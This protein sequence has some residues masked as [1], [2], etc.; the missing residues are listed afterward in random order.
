MSTRRPWRLRQLSKSGPHAN[1][2]TSPTSVRMIDTPSRIAMPSRL[3]PHWV[4]QLQGCSRFRAHHRARRHSSLSSSSGYC[5]SRSRASASSTYPRLIPRAGRL[6]LEL[7]AATLDCLAGRN[8]KHG[9]WFLRPTP[10]R[11]DELELVAALAVEFPPTTGCIGQVRIARTVR[12]ADDNLKDV[13]RVG[14]GT[15]HGRCVPQV[16]PRAP[17]TASDL[18]GAASRRGQPERSASPFDWQKGAIELVHRILALGCPR[19]AP[20]SAMTNAPCQP[21]W[22]ATA[23]NASTTASADAPP[24]D[25]PGQQRADPR[26]PGPTVSRAPTCGQTRLNTSGLSRLLSGGSPRPSVQQLRHPQERFS[27]GTREANQDPFH[28]FQLTLFA[29]G[30]M[31]GSHSGAE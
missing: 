28:E 26:H 11:H 30:Q 17:R 18:A 2:S 12:L 9:Q 10:S 19:P 25:S 22:T 1:P 23:S 8:P 14:N 3:M 20:T 27:I 6:D 5:P 13:G 4:R 29:P 15:W 7:Q 16:D 24:A 21:V 31:T